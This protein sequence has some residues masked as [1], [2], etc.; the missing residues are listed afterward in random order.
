MLTGCNAYLEGQMSDTF[1]AAS[2]ERRNVW[3]EY[4]SMRFW[5]RMFKVIHTAP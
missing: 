4:Y 5:H 2:S 1:W 3:I